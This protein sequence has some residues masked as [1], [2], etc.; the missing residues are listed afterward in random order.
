ML[1][2]EPRYNQ[3]HENLVGRDVR[4]ARLGQAVLSLQSIRQAAKFNI[5]TS[6]PQLLR[7][8][9][10][11][12]HTE[13]GYPNC[14]LFLLD[15]TGVQMECVGQAGFLEDLKLERDL[16]NDWRPPLNEDAP[17]GRFGLIGW[18]G[19]H[20]QAVNVPDVTK[21]PRYISLEKIR[22]TC[23][24]LTV[25]LIDNDELLGVLD[26]QSQQL[27]AFD[28][29]DLEI[30]SYFASAAASILRTTHLSHLAALNLETLNIV[31]A[32]GSRFNSSLEF[33]EISQ[34]VLE[35]IV[36]AMGG[37]SGSF[38]EKDDNSFYFEPLAA[39]N[40]NIIPEARPL[41]INP[42]VIDALENHKLIL[43]PDLA[44]YNASEITLDW[45]RSSQIV[46]FA[47]LPLYMRDQTLGILFINYR[48]AHQFS[49]GEKHLMNI[50][51]EQA[52]AAL[53]N[54][55]ISS[56]EQAARRVAESLVRSSRQINSQMELDKVLTTIVEEVTQTLQ[57][58]ACSI[59]LVAEN[60]VDI[61]IATLLGGKPVP[62]RAKLKT[63]QGF[64]GKIAATGKR[65]QEYDIALLPEFATNSVRIREGWHGNIGVPIKLHGTDKVI[66]VLSAYDHVP[67]N[68]TT[69]EAA[70]L[71]GLADQAAIALTN[72][73]ISK[74]EQIARRVAESLV[75][76]SRVV[77]SQLELDSVV[78]TITEEVRQILGVPVCSFML[79]DDSAKE[80]KV[81]KIKGGLN[82][83]SSI[84][85]LTVGKGFIG[86]IAATGKIWQ[87]YD[88]ALLPEFA[89]NPIRVEEGWRAAIGVPI[90]SSANQKTL[91]VL[92]VYDYVPRNFAAD[93]VAFMEGLADQAAIA[94]TNSRNFAALKMERDKHQ[95]LLSNANDPI[96]LI[97]PA[98]Q[99]IIDANHRATEATGYS[100]AEL[101][102]LPVIRLYQLPKQSKARGLKFL[103]LPEDT[104]DAINVENIMLRRKDGTLLP[105][106]YSARLVQVGAEYIVIQIVR[107]MTE[108]R[109]MEQQLLQSEKLRALGQLASG[110]AHDFNN[111]LTGILGVGELLLN[112]VPD[113]EEQRLLKMVRQ[114][115]L[116]GAHMVRRLQLLAPNQESGIFSPIEINSLLNDVIEL[117]RPRWR[118]EAQQNGINIEV[119]L[120]T[121]VIPP[122]NGNASELREVLTNLV[123]NAVDA[124]PQ[125]GRLQIG[126]RLRN[127]QAVI[128]I[129]DNGI[130]MSD[131]TKRRLFEPFY[132]TKNQEGHGLGLSVSSS[133]IARHRG[134]IEVESEPGQGSC[135]TLCLPLTDQ[136]PEIVNPKLPTVAEIKIISRRI[137][138]VD[139]EPNLVYILRRM[140]QADG[141]I[142][143]TTTN[144]EEAM[145]IFSA[146]PDDFDLVLSD[147]SIADVSG[148]Q[149]A[150]TIKKLRPETPVVLV[151][152]WGSELDPEMLKLHGITA[153]INKP[154][155]LDDVQN[156]I[157]RV[158]G[159]E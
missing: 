47:A 95:A 136:S 56:R 130:G 62:A 52:S 49:S 101:V 141:H 20:R 79:V 31:S 41:H 97:N 8:L 21:D 112:G 148:W 88:L 16:L 127:G 151:T 144:G 111:L 126:S 40:L 86:T 28:E 118:G 84:V 142:V 125:G 18:V 38:W 78:D 149:V 58:P 80:L 60:G 3:N 93:E 87:E 63:G 89:N 128:M 5:E 140:L 146:N 12:I 75:R 116:D 26:I 133:I 96:F 48:E 131:E 76:S 64:I 138:V 43:V 107:D 17:Q 65:W 54:A 77:S 13:L 109:A 102:G 115:A 19:S 90:K 156:T 147:L 74:R 71:E 30:A 158:S 11:I 105:V 61:E 134:T 83:A 42:L 154:Y 85:T 121:E 33:S 120:E 37:H 2:K 68:F 145:R 114:S 143:T 117:T 129:K 72:A 81:G 137:L 51:A 122:I 108:R 66:G 15:E 124:M 57:V 132:T 119:E 159:L 123:F 35:K 139:D 153:V 103:H 106:S 6:V 150:R 45:M 22:I 25:P 34:V 7:T 36:Q 59:A 39:F 113:D 50:F 27:N 67:R 10:E 91:G 55:R 152:G 14:Q 29:T 94:L 4:L 99:E 24:E 157:L 110:V 23:S 1:Q 135:L 73:R 32:T 70:F 44:N 155:R 92:C 9:V 53:F 82:S 104:Q 46:S 100:Y 98:N 69:E